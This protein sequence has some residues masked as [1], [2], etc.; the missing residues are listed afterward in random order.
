MFK[1]L[2]ITWHSLFETNA[3]IRI[4]LNIFSRRVQREKFEI[5]GK[6]SYW[7][8]PWFVLFTRYYWDDQIK[9][10]EMDGSHTASAWRWEMRTQCYLDRTQCRALVNMLMDFRV[11]LRGQLFYQLSHYKLHRP[12]HR[13]SVLYFKYITELLHMPYKVK[14]VK[15][16]LCL[17]N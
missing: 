12:S 8:T 5:D 6:F 16:F 14:K 10:D 11:V 1:K 15:F 9:D 17:F 7:G 13:L 4:N 3:S 2:H